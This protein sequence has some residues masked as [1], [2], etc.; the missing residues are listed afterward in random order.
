LTV[1]LWDLMEAPVHDVASLRRRT[2]VLIAVHLAIAVFATALI[3][4]LLLRVKLLVTISQRTNVETLLL[5]FLGAFAAVVLVTT[6][7]AIRGAFLLL[8]L[9]LR[10]AA[11]RQ[12]FIQQR[13]VEGHRDGPSFALLNL[14]VA[15]PDDSAIA[16]PLE[17][18]VGRLGVFRVR[19]VELVS[20]DAPTAVAGPLFELATAV[21]DDVAAVDPQGSSVTLVLWG[22]VDHSEAEVYRSQVRAFDR[23]SGA[24]GKGPLWPTARLDAGGLERL[25]KVLAEALPHLRETVLMPD[26]DYSAEFSI[27]LVPE[28]LAFVQIRRR[29]SRADPVASLGCAALM[30]LIALLAVVGVILFPPWV[31]SR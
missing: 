28:P 30:L 13:W 8:F 18:D 11:A 6:A 10:P 25:R 21:I 1:K 19:G 29:E 20:E 9:R 4:A 23:L 15:T 14:S 7:R 3:A 31:P 17:D 24:I 5:L 2:T 27:P 12:R 26:V 22:K 16:I